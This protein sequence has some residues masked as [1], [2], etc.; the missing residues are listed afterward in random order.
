MA[1]CRRVVWWAAAACVGVAILILGSV[2]A[3]RAL[4]AHHPNTGSEAGTASAQVKISLK[5]HSSFPLASSVSALVFTPDGKTLAVRLGTG[6]VQM[7][8][9]AT[10]A[11]TATL[12]SGRQSLP[13][14]QPSL[15]IS[16]NGK[17]VAFGINPNSSIPSTV[18]EVSV[19]TGKVRASMQVEDAEVYSV[20]FSPSGKALAIAAGKQLVF[21]NLAAHTVLVVPTD[22]MSLTGDAMYVSFSSDG[23]F[24]AVAGTDGLAKLWDVP[25]TGFTKSTTLR[26]DQTVTD[27]IAAGTISPDGETVA[28]SGSLSG[29]SASGTGWEDPETWLWH[30]ATGKMVLLEPANPQYG[31]ENG[32]SAQAFRPG[33]DVLATGDESGDIQLWDT[34]TGRL[35]TT[36]HAPSA[37][38][39]VTAAAFTS[40]GD[41]LATA[42]SS[43]A[44]PHGGPS[45]IQLW[46]LQ[47]ATG[48]SSGRIPAAQNGNAGDSSPSGRASLSPSALRPGDYRVARVIGITGSWVLTLNSVQ[49]AK[50][51]KATFI[52]EIR[53]TSTVEGQLSCA[54]SANPAEASITLA[55]GQVVN[56]VAGSCPGHSGQ[57]NI[58]VPPQGLL[59]SY[60]VFANTKGL[61]KPFIFDWN[62][63]DEFSGALSGIT[64]S[65]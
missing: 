25:T 42:Q 65:R 46:T 26:S 22:Q 60:V 50:D 36:K 45:T 37:I 7:R 12:G 53:N 1:S 35:V 17:D 11:L 21:W 28:L 27:E 2:A 3:F 10:G 51:G 24:V 52:V 15:A 44:P 41:W 18:E 64:L 57:G 8:N 49:V 33:E 13:G 16:P 30:P 39:P 38:S 48:P 34:A 14:P 62:G 19:T 4:V 59:E 6:A 5:L 43:L 23:K 31:T 58:S 56:S 40:K 9:A 29:N 63:P 55:T 32:I 47:S 61:G 20:A 54:G